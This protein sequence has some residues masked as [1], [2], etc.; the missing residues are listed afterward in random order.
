MLHSMVISYQHFGGACCLLVREVVV[1]CSKKVAFHN[2]QT[3]HNILEEYLQMR[4]VFFVLRQLLL[5]LLTAA[6][7]TTITTTTTTTTA[8]QLHLPFI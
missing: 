4:A 1:S 3:W 6:A 2:G 8:L 5:L 7:T